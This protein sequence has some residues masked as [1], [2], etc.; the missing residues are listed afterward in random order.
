LRIY[1]QGRLVADHAL[2]PPGSP[3]QEE[4]R[5]VLARRKLRQRPATRRLEGKTPRFDQAQTPQNGP[6]WVQVAPV[7]AARALETYEEVPC[8]R[9]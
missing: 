8:K 9:S 6:D 5:H 3:P 2:A 7:V 1:H 4:A